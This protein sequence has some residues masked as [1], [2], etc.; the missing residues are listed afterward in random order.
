MLANSSPALTDDL[1]EFLFKPGPRSITQQIREF[2]GARIGDRNRFLAAIHRDMRRDVPSLA[3]L[4]MSQFGRPVC[5]C[6]DGPSLVDDI[7]LIRRMK[8]NGARVIS[9]NRTHDKLIHKFGIT[10]FAHVMIDPQARVADYVE[11]PRHDVHYLLAAGVHEKT[12]AKFKGYP[13]YLW[14]PYADFPTGSEPQYAELKAMFPA[15]DPVILPGGTTVG[16]RSIW[17]AYYLGLIDQHWFGFDSSFHGDARNVSGKPQAD[18]VKDVTAKLID[19]NGATVEYATND[20]M[21]KQ[22]LDFEDLIS[23]QIP[24]MLKAGTLKPVPRFTVHGRGLLPDY[25]RKIGLH[26]ES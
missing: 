10:P 13:H 5:I 4:K 20:H 6:G 11:S 24:D 3:R 7:P 23:K 18:G 8:A 19:R 26:A 2:N 17:V 14:I 25:A 16:L 15:R 1:A 22:Q 12:W 21:A 9:V